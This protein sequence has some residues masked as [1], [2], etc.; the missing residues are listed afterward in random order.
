MASLTN[1]EKHFYQNCIILPP[2]CDLSNS[3]TCRDR[4]CIF[5]FTTSFKFH[6]AVFHSPKTFAL[7]CDCGFGEIELPPFAH[8][9]KSH[10]IFLDHENREALK[11]LIS[12]F[13]YPQTRHYRKIFDCKS[14]PKCAWRSPLKNMPHT[15][16]HHNHTYVPKPSS[17]YF[18]AHIP[19]EDRPNKELPR[20]SLPTISPIHNYPTDLPPKRRNLSAIGIQPL[21]SL[22]VAPVQPLQ[23]P[24][25]DPTHPGL[26]C[27]LNR[28]TLSSQTISAPP[29]VP[30]LTTPDTQTETLPSPPPPVSPDN[31]HA[32]DPP[33]QDALSSRL[34]EHRQI[35]K[36]SI[37]YAEYKQRFQPTPQT[38]SSI[39]PNPPK[40]G[41]PTKSTP[42]PD[43]VAI[44]KALEA[45]RTICKK[46]YTS[47]ELKEFENASWF[48]AHRSKAQKRD[49]KRKRDTIELAQAN[50]PT[51]TD[52]DPTTLLHMQTL[53]SKTDFPIHPAYLET[54]TIPSMRKVS[55][56]PQPQAHR[57]VF[58]K[59]EKFVFAGPVRVSER[60]PESFKSSAATVTLYE[61]IS[62]GQYYLL[63]QN[64][65]CS[66]IVHISIHPASPRF[67]E[68]EI[69]PR[70]KVFNPHHYPV[71]ATL[72]KQDQQEG[73]FYHMAISDYI[74]AGR[75][76]LIPAPI[77][78]GHAFPTKVNMVFSY[79]RAT[80][81]STFKP[82]TFKSWVEKKFG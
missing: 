21:L 10:G 37:T 54:I 53:L 58:N 81:G 75:Y 15:C 12:S 79:N 52:V 2:S 28:R 24:T 60:C 67:D 16:L 43:D 50:F 47:A 1:L 22:E 63:T 29:S 39:F 31:S 40:P 27:P 20:C 36:T 48:G 78:E 7:I 35:H 41:N 19:F 72:E 26:A 45:E 69:D 61:Y 51:L 3:K 4:L 11:T 77:A 6:N 9:L 80:F 64:G 17:Q 65:S 82:P 70:W 76:V 13:W 32:L 55:T 49:A 74:P 33:V 56:A 34:D 66:A 73:K 42:H 57:F 23:T 30:I 59:Q 25:P 62:Q 71:V 14:T 8:H 68:P 46:K 38:S 5:P 44:D 18:L